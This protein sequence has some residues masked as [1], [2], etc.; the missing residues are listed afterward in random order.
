MKTRSI[1]T[2][3]LLTAVCATYAAEEETIEPF[4]WSRAMLDL[5][6]LGDVARGEEI[7][8][9]S[10]CSK[11]HGDE[12][13]AE[14][15]ES[16]TIAGQVASY[17]FKQMLDYKT[18]VR[19]SKDMKKATK[20]LSLQD[21]S[22][23]AAYF[24]SLPPEPPEGKIEPPMLVTTGDMDRLLLPCNVCHGK[25]G[26]GLGFEV[27][28]IAGQKIDHFVEVMTGFQQGD[29]ENDHY[30][31][32]RFIAGQLSED[33]ISELAAYYAAPPTEEE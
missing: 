7:A 15:D 11:C 28:A 20:N 23:L 2:L 16:P 17:N 14:D 24:A 19:E 3:G 27:P 1:L 12:G 31:R 21:M 9:K 26:E 10:K 13:I 8:K 6:S 32:M 33:E 29:R 22:D 4:V 30:G 18:E 25:Q 5:I